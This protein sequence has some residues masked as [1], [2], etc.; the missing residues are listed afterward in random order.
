MGGRQGENGEERIKGKKA[1]GGRPGVEDKERKAR[2]QY[3]REGRGW[4]EME[5]IKVMG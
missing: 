1:M 3:G 4:E 5:G 2:G